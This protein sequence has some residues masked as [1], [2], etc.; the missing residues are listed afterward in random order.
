MLSRP[1]TQSVFATCQQQRSISIKSL[2]RTT[3]IS[4]NVFAQLGQTRTASRIIE[5][6]LEPDLKGTIVI[7]KSLN[8]RAISLLYILFI[9]IFLTGLNYWIRG[10]DV[11][12]VLNIHISANRNVGQL[13]EAIKRHTSHYFSGIHAELLALHQV[14][15]LN[16]ENLKEKLKGAVMTSRCGFPPICSP[17]FFV[18]SLNPHH[19][20]VVVDAPASAPL[21]SQPPSFPQSAEQHRIRAWRHRFL[22]DN[23]RIAPSIGA[24]PSAPY[25][26]F[27]G[28]AWDLRPQMETLSVCLPLHYH[29]TDED[30][31]R[32]VA[33]HLGALKKAVASL[34]EYY[35][36]LKPEPESQE[37]LIRIT[38]WQRQIF[39]YPRSFTSLKD[40]TL[41]TFEYERQPFGEK[42]LFFCEKEGMRL[43][44]K[45]VRRYSKQAHEICAEKGFAPALRGFEKIAGVGLWW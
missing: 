14:Y 6:V 18:Q 12:N 26:A 16:E 43:C 13:K 28:A 22:E 17:K 45:S 9:D 21:R 24:E 41:Q 37:R 42:L 1:R 15:L 34:E 20:H 2:G 31:R 30:T 19:V 33:R 4:Y 29:L 25:I 10:T 32:K 36:N 39:H 7:N 11:G 44:V 38:G 40:G 35:Q 27:A 8:I 23:V 5:G 3:N